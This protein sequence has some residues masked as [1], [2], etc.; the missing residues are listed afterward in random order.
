MPR[1]DEGPECGRAPADAV[2]L[3]DLCW[4]GKA[5]RYVNMTKLQVV[6]AH[7]DCLI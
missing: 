3:S 4:Q 2:L 1:G 6:D 5:A 7:D